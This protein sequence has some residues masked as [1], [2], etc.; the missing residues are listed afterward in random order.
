MSEICIMKLTQS[1]KFR[2]EGM[3][4]YRSLLFIPGN[5]P[6][7]MANINQTEVDAIILDLEDSVPDD[8]KA[9]A[10]EHVKAALEQ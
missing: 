6:K 1:I 3:K 8:E 2:G 9:N 7:W 4:V 5:K 10:R